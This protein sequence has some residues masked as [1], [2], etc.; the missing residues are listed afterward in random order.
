MPLIVTDTDVLAQIAKTDA[1]A[2]SI[3]AQ[4]NAQTAKLAPGTLAAWQA[5]LTGYRAW[6]KTATAALSGGFLGGAWFGVPE[7]GDQA[8][9]YEATLNAWQAQLNA[10]SGQQIAPVATTPDQAANANASVPGINAPGSS[11][12]STGVLLGVAGLAVLLLV[13]RK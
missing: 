6:S 2:S 4:M 12:I 5:F 1:Q 7:L 11:G 8:A 3:D 13:V 9:A 10:A